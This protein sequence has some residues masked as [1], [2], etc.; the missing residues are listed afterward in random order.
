MNRTE[1]LIYLAGII[2]GEGS[3]AIEI[4]NVNATC[5]KTDYYSI[6]LVVVNTSTRLMDFLTTNFGG[7]VFYRRKIINRKPCFTW[8]L[9]SQRA[10]ELLSECLPYMIIKKDRAEI[11]IEFTKTKEGKGYR[12]TQEVQDARRTLYAKM[13][14]LNK[15][16]D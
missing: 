15:L 11:L 1:K 13:K 4:Q 5:R 7:T 3:L 6:R 16:G 2:D 8:A 9:L 12:V 10:A 14:E